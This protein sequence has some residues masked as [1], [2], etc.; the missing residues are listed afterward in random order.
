MLSSIVMLSLLLACVSATWQ[1]EGQ[2]EG[3]SDNPYVFEER[4]FFTGMQSQ[5]GR[6][7]VLPKFTDRSPLLRGIENYRVTIFEA[8]PQ[9]FV[10]P[11]HWDADAVFF[12]ANGTITD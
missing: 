10:L 12:V 3:F 2:Q 9:T 8:E 6:V 7:R 4:H 1:Q 5:H 11:N